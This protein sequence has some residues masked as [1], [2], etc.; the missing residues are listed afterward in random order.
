MTKC[1][2]D[3]CD[4]PVRAK[5]MCIKHYM[6][7]QRHGK[8]FRLRPDANVVNEIGNGL[9]EVEMRNKK[10]GVIVKT[11]IDEEFRWV[12]EKHR[13]YYH[14]GY[15]RTD[16]RGSKKSL[17]Q[18][19]LDSD[20]QVDHINKDRLDN[21]KSNLRACTP[22][23]NRM[24]MSIRID[25]ASGVSGVSWCKE[26]KKWRA[27]L[28]IKGRQIHCGLFVNKSDAIESRLNAEIKYYG[29]F[30]PQAHSLQI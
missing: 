30:A 19:I 13:F 4:S 23:Q 14:V 6:Q 2:V 7:F 26:L 5:G 20:D 27:Y 24:N 17:H 9:L 3:W 8:F 15:A 12:V 21:R 18:F 28:S 22:Q 29:E 25:N 1:L 16:F 11:I 10:T